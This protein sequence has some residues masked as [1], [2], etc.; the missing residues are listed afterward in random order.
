LPYYS[1]FNTNDPDRI[2]NTIRRE[3]IK[4]RVLV[5]IGVSLNFLLF[6]FSLWKFASIPPFC[7]HAQFILI[8]TVCFIIY[9]AQDGNI[10][11]NFLSE[12]RAGSYWILW[13]HYVC[14]HQ[15]LED[16]SSLDCFDAAELIKLSPTVHILRNK[17]MATLFKLAAA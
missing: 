12:L 14:V 8:A 9:E 7:V 3:I 6:C 10:S 1:S 15:E 17:K 11:T 16:D 13:T 2:K 4:F 5:A